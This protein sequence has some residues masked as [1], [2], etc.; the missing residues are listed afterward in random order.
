MG[1]ICS[2]AGQGWLNKKSSVGVGPTLAGA[3]VGWLEVQAD[4]IR[5]VGTSNI[6]SAFTPSSSESL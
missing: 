6:V 5:I 2:Q 1:A 3:G 4:M